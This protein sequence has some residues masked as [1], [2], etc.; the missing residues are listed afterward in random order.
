MRSNSCLILAAVAA[1]MSLSMEASAQCVTG[2]P[3]GT[4]P[5]AGAVTGTWDVS[6]PTNP[7]V[8]VLAVTVPAGATVL[9]S[10]RLNGL[11]HSWGG[12]CHIILQD[13]TGQQ[14]NILVRSDATSSGGGGCSSPFSGNY[15]VVDPITGGPCAGNSPIGCPAGTITPGVYL[16]D[17]ST[18]TSGS[19]GI[20]NTPIE[21]I[22]ISNGNWTLSIYDWYPPADDG[23]LFDWDLCFGAPTPP[24]PPGGGPPTTCVT[25]G[26]GGSYPGP[27]AVE[28]TW[29]T[30]M[31]TG[32]LIAPLA[33]TVPAGSTKLISVKLNSFNHTW[34]ADTQIVLQAPSGQMYNLFHEQD[35]T[36]GG[37]CS[38]VFSGDY[39]F[40]DAVLGLDACGNPANAFTCVGG[41]V[42]PGYYLQD[43]G[44][45]TSGTNGINNTNLE[46]IPIASG[47]WNLIFYDWFIGAD[48]GT[49][50]SWD[51]CFD[52]A[53]V[54]TYCTAKINSLGCTPSI[55]STGAS[56]ATAGSG[57][58]L[59]TINVINNKPGLYLYTN[60]GRA[61]IPFQGGL[62][63]VN[64]PVR[65]STPMLSGGNPPPN[66]CSG[67]YVIDFNAF[68]VG[69]LGG[70]P[71]PYLTVPGTVID[72]QAW[73][74]DN[75]IPAPNNSTL[76]N[77]LEFTVGP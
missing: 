76:S 66:D 18:W 8:S 3:G 56:S 10:V 58:V 51:L 43:Y 28:G 61:A 26:A 67:A 29:P 17:F 64:T 77:A 60:T 34:A 47:T 23:S 41:N 12:D 7:L 40:V 9:N 4:F 63:C 35:G 69:A 2:G 15:E 57:F 74:R 68:A 31:P 25:G 55:G 38:D 44:I 13:P 46:S 20:L 39:A 5:G 14:Y 62:R 65:R 32:E 16:Q 36:F 50:G 6:L 53:S 52:G 72:A 73:G 75:G 27:G 42:A 70:T 71:Q 33:V 21:S 49:L 11:T 48:S 59:T 19:A 1:S 45:W 54:T 37:G 30:V 24:P 22:P